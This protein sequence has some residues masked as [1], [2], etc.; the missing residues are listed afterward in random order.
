MTKEQLG[1][2]RSL[3]REISELTDKIRELEAKPG[4]MVSD[5][6]QASMK[7]FPY[8]ETS[9]KIEGLD[10]VHDR[11]TRQ[12]IESR[13]MLLIERRQQA[14]ELEL[15]ITEYINRVED[16]RLR[17]MME[18]RYVEGKTWEQI[19]TIMNCDRTTAEKSITKYL[20]EN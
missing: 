4:T 13:K 2:L 15:Q 7:D 16:S 10:M 12:Q 8:I 14:Q 6:V 17:R 11:K 19:G 1:Q 9:V 5:K 3:R 20:Q 18:Y